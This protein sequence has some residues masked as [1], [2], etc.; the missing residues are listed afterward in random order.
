MRKTAIFIFL[1]AAGAF[2]ANAQ[3]DRTQ[4]GSKTQSGTKS[5]TDQST[6]DKSG[7]S[8][9]PES[10]RGTQLQ[11]SD[12]PKAVSDDISSKH[13]GWTTQEVYKTDHQ[14][15]AAYEVVVK[16]DNEHKSLVYDAKGNLL[17]TEKHSMGTSGKSSGSSTSGSGTGSSTRSG[18]TS[19]SGSTGSGTGDDTY[20]SGS[21]TGT[22][23]S[24]GSGSTGTSSPN[25]STGSGSSTSPTETR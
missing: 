14:G 4:S 15:S 22:G 5:S 23:S 25:S 19:G 11:I 10:M 12:L 8:T 3:D 13:K 17:K 2:I 20:N 1:L 7:T 9:S 24:T 18:S 16:K 21:S 6:M